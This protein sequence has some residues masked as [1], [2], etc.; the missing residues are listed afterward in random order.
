[1]EFVKNRTENQF[2]FCDYCQ[3]VFLFYFLCYYEIAGVIHL[4]AWVILGQ[5]CPLLLLEI[6]FPAESSFNPVP[7]HLPVIIK[8]S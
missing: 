1:M 3:S 7:T 2:T 6:Y 8:C 5:G 4:V